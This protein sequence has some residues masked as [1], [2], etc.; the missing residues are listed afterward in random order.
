MNPTHQRPQAHSQHPHQ[1][2]P[3]RQPPFSM[4][5]VNMTGPSPQGHP[6]HHP[7][8]LQQQS[9]PLAG[10]NHINPMQP[11]NAAQHPHHMHPQ[12]PQTSMPMSM[13]FGPPPSHMQM[14]IPQ[15]HVSI[16]HQIPHHHQ[17]MH[18]QGQSL[19]PQ[20][21]SPHAQSPM[22][23]GPPPHQTYLP[24]MA[25]QQHQLH[26]QSVLYSQHYIGSY[27]PM[28]FP[29]FAMQ[30]I[31]RH[32]AIS[33][34]QTNPAIL[35]QPAP[36]ITNELGVPQ[37]DPHG[38]A[39]SINASNNTPTIGSKPHLP[40]STTVPAPN[41][42]PPTREKKL[43]T[44]RDPKRLHPFTIDELQG[45]SRASNS[46]SSSSKDSGV[47]GISSNNPSISSDK[48][49][50]TDEASAAVTVEPAGKVI[51]EI[52]INNKAT[53]DLSS[54]GATTKQVLKVNLSNVKENNAPG[55]PLKVLENGNIVKNK[56]R[57]RPPSP[58]AYDDKNGGKLRV[59]MAN[60][61]ITD[62]AGDDKL[63]PGEPP[64]S[65]QA[66]QNSNLPYA[67]GQFSPLNRNGQRKYTIEF[68]KAVATEKLGYDFSRPGI[69]RIDFSPH[70]IN[71]NYSNHK[72]FQSS[73]PLMRRSSQQIPIRRKVIETHSLGQEAELKTVENPWKPE[74]EIEK[75]KIT[76]A[77]EMDTKRLLKVFRGHLNKLTPQK[78]EDIIEKIALLEFADNDKLHDVINLV[79]DKAVDEPGFCGLYASMCKVI[80]DKH[81]K[82]STHL[83]RKCQE[84]FETN[85]L[86]DG[87]DVENRRNNIATE[88]DLNKKKL[89][90]E[91]LYEDMRQRRRKY[92]GTIKL[93]GEMYKLGLL[94]AKIIGFC[95]QHLLQDATNENIECLCG[96]ITTVGQ[97]MADESDPQVK[98]CLSRTLTIL[99]DI[100]HSK[101]CDQLE[102]ESRIKFKI[103]DTVDLSRREWRPRMV[104][105]NP[106][107]IEEIREEVK[108]EHSR[109]PHFST[110]NQHK[111]VSRPSDDRDRRRPNSSA[112][113]KAGWNK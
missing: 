77:G 40:G 62:K 91:E 23:P 39:P 47:T 59:E 58:V 60:L 82:F 112:Y 56:E 106:K 20:Q 27:N 95:I 81:N 3:V 101:K 54:D 80:A 42:P 29:Q 61:T 30:P 98:A 70:Y 104:G 68:L 11:P 52:P 64:V 111:S 6:P 100:A 4:P 113:M 19:Q 45:S 89:L 105:N 12:G 88:A 86:Y 17:P 83:V 63:S 48:D 94:A 108:E 110:H 79:F 92:L 5:Q 31:P 84:E 78:Y 53:A 13:G 37:V 10:P 38:R 22:Q 51:T 85:D 21:P 35:H 97:K 1:P 93:I 14:P 67:A 72:D 57:S 109:Q 7:P 9:Q 66:L 43:A 18:Q 73:Q 32:Y 55:E 74:L 24:P 99:N 87:L 103:L 50:S 26:P 76:E 28:S 36:V 69:A 34:I 71:Q 41:V 90:N 15:H 65:K 102:L 33:P 46:Q 107:K 75:S 8:H 44:I 2:P 25:H 49:S 96:L 16:P